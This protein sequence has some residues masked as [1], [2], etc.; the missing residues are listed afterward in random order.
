MTNYFIWLTTGSGY[1]LS[2]EGGTVLLVSQGD[3]NYDPLDDYYGNLTVRK[4]HNMFF[5][6]FVLKQNLALD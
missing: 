2:P 4:L 5:Y 6:G 3:F 1:D